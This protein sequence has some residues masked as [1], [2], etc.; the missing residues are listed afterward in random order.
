[1]IGG[2]GKLE[3]GGRG[4]AVLTGENRGGS[5]S[6]W[7]GVRSED[8]VWIRVTGSRKWTLL[9]TMGLGWG[10]RSES[11]D[12]EMGI[13]VVFG[14]STRDL[15]LIGSGE[16]RGERKWVERP[17]SDT[18]W[19]GSGSGHIEPAVVWVRRWIAGP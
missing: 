19:G 5:W 1:M 14:G 9:R 3:A 2:I 4:R 11:W 12:G 10:K 6:R 17:G 15:G 18:W 7:S 8:P 13:W 16:N